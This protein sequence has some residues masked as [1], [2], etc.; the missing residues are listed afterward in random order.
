[1]SKKKIQRVYVAGLLTPR[2]IWD[3][4]PAIDYLINVRHLIR[5]GIELLLAGYTPF[6]PA[7]DFAVFLLLREDKGERIDEVMIKKYSMDWLEVCDAVMLTDGWEHSTG[8]TAE[9]FNAIKHEQPVFESIDALKEY[10][11]G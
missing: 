2:G 8:T 7:L 4:N 3:K 10:D 6:I 5:A 1:M 11:N 9:I